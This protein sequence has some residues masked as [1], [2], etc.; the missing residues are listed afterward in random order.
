MFI[1]DKEHQK[2]K[3]LR[4]R[5]MKEDTF[6]TLIES[7]NSIFNKISKHMMKN[8][9][10]NNYIMTYIVPFENNT[11]EFVAIS[12]LRDQGVN[13]GKTIDYMFSEFTK[14]FG[15]TSV[16]PLAFSRKTDVETLNKQFPNGFEAVRVDVDLK[17]STLPE[18]VFGDWQSETIRKIEI[19]LKAVER[20]KKIERTAYRI[21][22]IIEDRA[23][24]MIKNKNYKIS[25]ENY[26]HAELTINLSTLL[27][28]GDREYF[29]SVASEIIPCI[30]EY[31]KYEDSDLIFSDAVKKYN[32][33]DSNLPIIRCQLNIVLNSPRVEN[34]K[35]VFDI[36]ETPCANYKNDVM[37][38][39]N[40]LQI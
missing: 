30:E 29:F 6:N 9:I 15:F 34:Q 8:E 27:D 4:M 7:V 40:N 36:G 33:E 22:G 2:L 39:I 12:M 24:E 23:N 32:P 5:V 14:K 37:E 13:S 16:I 21:R 3:Q 1:E 19:H 10:A 35:T 17:N 18:L 11:P 20:R 26:R 28:K 38:Y 25:D 31:F